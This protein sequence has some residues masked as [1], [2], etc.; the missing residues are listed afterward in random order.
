MVDISSLSALERDVH[1]LRQSFDVARRAM[2]LSAPCSS[3]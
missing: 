3:T 2:T 1:F